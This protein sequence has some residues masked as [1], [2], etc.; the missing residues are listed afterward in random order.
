MYDVDEYVYGLPMA[1]GAFEDGQGEKDI[2]RR[3]DDDILV[4]S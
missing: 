3:L 4:C 1:F 2:I